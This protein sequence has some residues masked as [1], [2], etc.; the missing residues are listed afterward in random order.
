MDEIFEFVYARLTQEGFGSKSWNE[1]D[2]AKVIE[3]QAHNGETVTIW[4]FPES[5]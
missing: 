5:Q 2:G 4:F 3:V 1:A